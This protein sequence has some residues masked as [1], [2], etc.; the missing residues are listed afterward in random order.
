MLAVVLWEVEEVLA[1]VWG[2]EGGRGYGKEL[3]RLCPAGTTPRVVESSVR[4][5]FGCW[6]RV[7]VGTCGNPTLCGERFCRLQC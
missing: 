5:N 7:G 3:A 6:K 4:G 2:G 1:V